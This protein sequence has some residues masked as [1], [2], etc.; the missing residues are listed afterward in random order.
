[1]IVAA[2]F[3]LTAAHCVTRLTE[4]FPYLEVHQDVWVVAG[5]SLRPTEGQKFSFAFRGTERRPDMIAPHELYPT[6]YFQI[7]DVAVLYFVD[8]LP[9]GSNSFVKSIKIGSPIDEPLSG[10]RAIGWGNTKWRYTRVYVY[11]TQKERTEVYRRNGYDKMSYGSPN[12]LMWG[13][14]EV[15]SGSRGREVC[16][17]S[18]NPFRHYCVVSGPE[19]GLPLKG[20]SGGPLVCRS[21]RRDDEGEDVVVGTVMYGDNGRYIIYS[22]LH[23]YKKWLMGVR[24][25][26][27]AN[28]WKIKELSSKL[29]EMKGVERKEKERR[30]QER[31]RRKRERRKERRRRRREEQARGT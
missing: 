12:R 10:C 19:G 17:D 14:V 22:R 1:M 11:G 5:E 30:R 26:V 20:D 15:L 29:Q 21:R 27:V 31:N 25:K 2:N 23:T 8:P 4:E 18:F 24:Q 3:V 13:R 16:H 6:D 28:K 9:I 7:Y